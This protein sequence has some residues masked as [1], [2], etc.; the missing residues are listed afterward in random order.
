MAGGD[1]D[2]TA[3]EDEE[4]AGGDVT[5]EGLELGDLGGPTGEDFLIF[6]ASSSGSEAEDQGNAKEEDE[7][8]DDDLDDSDDDEEEEEEAESSA[9]EQEDQ[10]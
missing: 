4:G 3:P 10:Y 8:Y 9:E 2:P 7:D 1:A 5:M 6:E